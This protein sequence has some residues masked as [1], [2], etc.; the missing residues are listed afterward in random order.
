MSAS[1]AAAFGLVLS[2]AD[3]RLWVQYQHF[4]HE[5]VNGTT[6]RSPFF[7]FFTRRPTL[8]TSPMNSWPRM[9]PRCIVGTRPFT[10]WRSDPQIAVDVMRTMTSP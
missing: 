5:I 6:T 8:T 2:H 3:Q 7:N 9:S 4:P 10:R 1:R